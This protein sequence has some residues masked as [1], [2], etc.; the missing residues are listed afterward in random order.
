MDITP[1]SRIG[2]IA[3][4]HPLST[5][6]FDRHR[7]DFCC[8]GG[9]AL[10][11]ACAERGLEVGRVLDEIADE[12]R[13]AGPEPSGWEDAPTAELVRHIL[14]AYHAPLREELPRIEAMA[15]KV[16]RVHGDKDP[17]RLP[18]L[19]ETVRS[20]RAELEDHMLREELE[21]FPALLGD[22]GDDVPVAVPA[23]YV[24]DH[25]AAGRA[26]ERIRELTDDFRVPAAACN[27]WRALWHALADLE[28]AMHQHV[29]LE[30]NVLFRRAAA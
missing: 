12:L 6:V 3:A 15:L 10:E 26:L 29:H 23:S 27:T 5:R 19:A 28:R 21:L 2:D 20:L 22:G 16:A 4:R 25:E 18:A 9:V 11:R 14:D 13:T 8:G 17:E 1:A 24:D 7:I 30:N